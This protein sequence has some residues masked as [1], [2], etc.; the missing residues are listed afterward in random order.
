MFVLEGE[1]ELLLWVP[2]AT[3]GYG[4]S[5]LATLLTYD[6]D[7][8]C[9]ADSLMFILE[10]EAE[11]VLWVPRAAG[12]DTGDTLP[13]TWSDDSLA[14][15]ALRSAG[16]QVNSMLVREEELVRVCKMAALR[17]KFIWRARTPATHCPV[18]A[19]MAAWRSRRC[20]PP[21]HCGCTLMN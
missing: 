8:C 16:S 9:A 15:E 4:A 12:E 3:G 6:V 2:R 11:V 17:L 13:T 21:V 18:P 20:A 19:P 1:A 5:R 10:G 14:P 7:A